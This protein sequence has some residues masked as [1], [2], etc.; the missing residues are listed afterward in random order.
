MLDEELDSEVVNRL[1]CW[2]NSNSTI[3]DINS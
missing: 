1:Y 3:V 2:A